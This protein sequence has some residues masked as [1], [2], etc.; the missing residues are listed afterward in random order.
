MIALASGRPD[1]YYSFPCTIAPTRTLPMPRPPAVPGLGLKTVGNSDADF[2]A[3]AVAHQSR[4]SSS[5]NHPTNF[6]HPH[7]TKP[8]NPLPPSHQLGWR[9][10]EACR[11][12][13]IIAAGGCPKGYAHQ[14]QFVAFD[15]HPR[16][17]SRPAPFYSTHRNFIPPSRF[18]PPLVHLQLGL[19]KPHKRAG[20]SFPVPR[21]GELV[22]SLTLSL[23]RVGVCAR[24]CVCVRAP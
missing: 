23:A 12:K 11:A 8:V 4:R 5:G 19:G 21:I 2:T 3:V 15:A 6:H 20:Q 10:T 13:L 16:L 14:R 22:K 9:H 24:V 7:L 1:E 17:P 18:S